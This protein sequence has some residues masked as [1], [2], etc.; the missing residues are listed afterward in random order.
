MNSVS[1]RLA[2][3]VCDEVTAR[4]P[5]RPRFVA[6]ALGRTDQSYRLD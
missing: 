6:G 3:D 2:R 5:T 1:A 4:D